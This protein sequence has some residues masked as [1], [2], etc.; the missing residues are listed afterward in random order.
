M[1]GILVV[2]ILFSSFA[3]SA[4]RMQPPYAYGG[5]AALRELIR[6]EMVYPLAA[7]QDSAEGTVMINFV[8]NAD[9][10]TSHIKINERTH[11]AL[12]KEAIRLLSYVKWHPGLLYNYNTA[13]QHYFKVNFN[14]RRY[15]KWCRM[16]GYHTYRLPFPADESATIIPFTE[17]DE[18]PNLILPDGDTTFASFLVQ[19]LRYPHEAFRHSMEGV[20]IV[21]FVVEPSGRITNLDIEKNVGGG[22]GSEALRLM[23]LLGWTPGFIDGKAVRSQMEFAIQFRLPS[24]DSPRNLDTTR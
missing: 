8:V 18:T 16:R 23:R 7:L 14:M 20:V 1:R 12:E 2:L 10:S 6:N 19:N 5:E 11:P 13:S 9:G 24:Q 15:Q 21:S 3:L 22:C 17:L 4:Q